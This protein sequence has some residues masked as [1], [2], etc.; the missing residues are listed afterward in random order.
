MP[1]SCDVVDQPSQPVLSIRTRSSQANLPQT[2]DKSFSAIVQ[3]LAEL[4]EQPVYAPFAA[5]YNMDMEDLDLEIGFPVA[6]ELPDKDDIK[7]SVIT[8][9]KYASCLHTGPYNEIGLAYQALTE[10]MQ[11]KG[12]QPS[13]VA[14]EYYLNDPTETPPQELQT[15]VVFPVRT[16]S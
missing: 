13:G 8:A 14:Y 15:R 11:E 10:W 7:S 4:G 12:Y 9:G 6:K 5:Y 3:Y 2:F 16:T 1:Y